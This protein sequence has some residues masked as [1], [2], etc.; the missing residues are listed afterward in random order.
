M[1]YD[2]VIVGAG[3]AGLAAARILTGSRKR[4][5]LIEARTRIGGRIFSLHPR[6]L[7]LPIEL[8]A[9]FIHGDGGPAFDIV[10][11]ASLAV[12]QLPDDHWWSTANGKRERIE[13]FWD[14]IDRVRAKI[15]SRTRDLSFAEFLRRRKDLA[16]RLRE[17]AQNFVEGYHAA[18]ADRIS[19]HVLRTA[20]EEQAGKNRQFRI[21][22]GQDALIAWLHAGLDPSLGEVLLGTVAERVQWSDRSVVVHCGDRRVRGKRLLLTIPIGVWKAGALAFDPPLRTKERA[23]ELL[24]PGHVVKI[25]FRFR[26]R[27][28]DDVNFLHT[29]D[30]FVQ[31]WWTAAPFR[32]PVLTAWAGGHAADALLAESADARIDHA[33]ASMASA[34]DVPR[35]R[36]DALLIG[37]FTHDWQSDP[38]SRC[39]YSY[40]AVG[41]AGAHD[42]LARP[43]RKTLYFAGEATSSDQT[44]TVAGA[45]ASGQRAA[46]EVLR[47]ERRA[48]VS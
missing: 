43:V 14:Q 27:F 45:I 36:L 37:T 10:D 22:N 23:L 24:E 29:S 47:D 12:A 39:A 4:V 17:L 46:T 11:A 31:T 26:E 35:R 34:W 19:A 1:T 33:L 28:W 25:A 7:P 6:E 48:L 15:G 44:G 5:C 32:A 40:A 38:F 13:G 42:A 30:R 8:G 9:E 21:V 3:A 41:G 18:H 16:P 20:D 2:V